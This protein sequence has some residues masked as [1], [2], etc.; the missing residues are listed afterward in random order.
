MVRILQ[1]T[2]PQLLRNALLGTWDGPG[3][4]SQTGTPLD[5]R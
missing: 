3:E 1:E 2:P 5:G 4:Q